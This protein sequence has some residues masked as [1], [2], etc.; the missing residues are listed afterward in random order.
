VLGHEDA[1]TVLVYAEQRRI[2]YSD[3]LKKFGAAVAFEEIANS[4]K[5]VAKQFPGPEI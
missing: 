2:D 1:D 3:Q 4:F 5:E